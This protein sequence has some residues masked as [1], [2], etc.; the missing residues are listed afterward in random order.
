[1]TL[2]ALTSMHD[3][4][5]LMESLYWR[6]GSSNAKIKSNCLHT[7]MKFQNRNLSMTTRSLELVY[8]HTKILIQWIENIFF[9]LFP[10]TT[11]IPW[12][13]LQVGQFLQNSEVRPPLQ[14]ICLGHDV[15]AEWDADLESNIFLLDRKLLPAYHDGAPEHCRVCGL[16]SALVRLFL[17]FFLRLF[18]RARNWQGST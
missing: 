1:M 13:Y 5:W 4:W 17:Y 6:K 10:N 15:L 2:G 18:L 16:I 12:W 3:G 14:M 7:W 8:R 9:V 11:N